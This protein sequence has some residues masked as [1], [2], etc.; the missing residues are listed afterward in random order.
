LGAR[1]EIVERIAYA[2]DI[3]V[4]GVDDRSGE[5]VEHAF[6]PAEV[7]EIDLRLRPQPFADDDAQFVIRRPGERGEK[8][9]RVSPLAFGHTH[10]SPIVSMPSAGRARRIGSGG[11]RRQVSPPGPRGQA[12]ALVS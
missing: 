12:V 10:R 4:F 9:C 3:V 2:D 7:L 8:A 5:Y 1:L 11:S 6:D